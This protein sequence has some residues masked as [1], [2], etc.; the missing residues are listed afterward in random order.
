MIAR[1]IICS[2]LGIVLSSS[3]FS[4]LKIDVFMSRE[5]LEACLES[6][7]DQSDISLEMQVDI[8]PN[9]SDGVIWIDNIN[10]KDYTSSTLYIFTITGNLVYQK[11]LSVIDNTH[12]IELNLNHLPGSLYFIRIQ[13]RKETYVGKI[14]IYK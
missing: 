1:F 2:I 7:I 8:Y 11:N 14:I 13:T 6:S 12:T 9:P 5:G 4:Q 3:L 10:I